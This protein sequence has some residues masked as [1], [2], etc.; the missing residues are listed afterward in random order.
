[1][2]GNLL[3]GVLELDKTVERGPKLQ[4]EAEQK[5]D[6]EQE[7]GLGPGLTQEHQG[8]L[9]LSCAPSGRFVIWLLDRL[10]TTTRWNR[11]TSWGTVLSRLYEASTT[12]ERAPPRHTFG[13]QHERYRG[14]TNHH[15]S[16]N[17]KTL[18]TS[19]RVLAA[20][21]PGGDVSASARPCCSG[22]PAVV[23]PPQE[24]KRLSCKV[25]LC[26][27]ACQD[28]L[29]PAGFRL[30]FVYSTS[31]ATR[32]P[33][34]QLTCI[35][36]ASAATA[37]GRCAKPQRDRPSTPACWLTQRRMRAPASSCGG[38]HIMEHGKSTSWQGLVKSTSWRKHVMHEQLVARVCQ[39]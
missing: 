37:S 29:G 22:Q 16:T 12:C 33:C 28:F 18:R 17:P 8:V 9:A 10:T 7:K 32:V 39:P 6:H 35:T 31:H 2:Q 36:G 14:R 3:A 15:S 1:M 26:S 25:C 23:H 20:T 30:C 19:E 5:E 27:L 24:T 11:A 38:K 4:L 34:P 13:P 21:G